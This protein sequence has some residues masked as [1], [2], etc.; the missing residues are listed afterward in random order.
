[1]KTA[2]SAVSPA[3]AVGERDGIANDERQKVYDDCLAPEMD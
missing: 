1:M 2:H 3:A